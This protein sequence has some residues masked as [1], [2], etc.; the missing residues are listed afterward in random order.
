MRRGKLL[1]FLGCELATWHHWGACVRICVL[2]EN[3][4]LTILR[5]FHFLNTV[6][7]SVPNFELVTYNILPKMIIW[8]HFD[9]SLAS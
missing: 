6:I 3:H 2:P 7:M 4:E 9:T 5:R 1:T 8:S